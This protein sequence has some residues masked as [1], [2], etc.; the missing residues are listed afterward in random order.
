MGR[1]RL[2]LQCKR[3]H[4]LFFSFSFPLLS[5]LLLLLLVSCHSSLDIL[6]ALQTPKSLPHF[7][8]CHSMG[9]ITWIFRGSSV[10]S[11]AYHDSSKLPRVWSTL[12]GNSLFIMCHSNLQVTYFISLLQVA[13]SP[14]SKLRSWYKLASERAD[15]E[16]MYQFYE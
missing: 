2:E 8:H 1:Y 10:R 5:T 11:T 6:W 14:I 3:L 9:T 16:G 4:L 12:T 13:A 7:S 15:I